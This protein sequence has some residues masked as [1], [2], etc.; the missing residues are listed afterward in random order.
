MTKKLTWRLS[1]LPTVEE[2]LQL[3]KD[4]VI[5]Q[6]EANEI[7][8]KEKDEEEVAD[9]NALREEIKFLKKL[10]EN[11]SKNNNTTIIREIERIQ[12]PYIHHPWYRPYEYWCTGSAA[13]TT[14]A[15]SSGGASGTANAG[16]TNFSSI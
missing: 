14:N 13:I 7:L 2:L 15:V 16:I 4:K 1:K 10:V 11:L 6:K 9:V 3:V 8:L 5:T 12:V